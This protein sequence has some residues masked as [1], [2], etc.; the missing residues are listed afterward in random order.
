MLSKFCVLLCIGGSPTGRR[1]P[2]R[3]GYGGVLDP[4]VGI[5]AGGGGGERW[6]GRVW[7]WQTRLHTQRVPSR[8]GTHGAVREVNAQTVATAA[9]A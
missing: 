1:Y 5:E 8:N 4:P 7:R 6:A 2:S 3:G 9:L